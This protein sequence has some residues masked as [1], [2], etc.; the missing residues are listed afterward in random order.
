MPSK[1]YRLIVVIAFLSIFLVKMGISAAPVFFSHLDKEVMKSVIMQLE[2][3]HESDGDSGKLLKIVEFKL[4]N[5]N[6][7]FVYIPLVYEVGIDNTFFD[8]NK[9]YVN[10]YHPSVPTPPPN[11]S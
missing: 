7:T 3:E 11:F 6:N 10:P 8:H 1:K 5:H 4:I 9:R 2:Q